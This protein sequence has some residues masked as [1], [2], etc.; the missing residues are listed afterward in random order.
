VKK[1]LFALLILIANHAANAFDE[2][3]TVVRVVPAE[4]PIRIEGLGGLNDYVARRCE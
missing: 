2:R 3:F 4:I 1:I